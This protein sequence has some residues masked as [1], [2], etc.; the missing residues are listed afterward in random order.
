MT[1]LVLRRIP[2]SGELKKLRVTHQ[3]VPLPGSDAVNGGG[4]VMT[5]NQA[6]ACH[7]LGAVSKPTT[8]R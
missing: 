8:Y 4:L 7:S 1:S 2:T 6:Q 5:M 3:V